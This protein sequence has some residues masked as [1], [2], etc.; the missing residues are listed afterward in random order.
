MNL[1]RRTGYVKGY[2]MIEYES[3]KEAQKALKCNILM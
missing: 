3:F 2:A 1:D